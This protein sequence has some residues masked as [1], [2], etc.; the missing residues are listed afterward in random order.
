[1]IFKVLY[2]KLAEEAPIRE[3]TTSLY[4]EADSIQD[5]REKLSGRDINIE[6]I[7]ALDGAHLAYEQRSE[8]FKLES[9]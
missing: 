6:H 9:L 1:M 7:H 3:H 8:H 4:L 2:Q 5:A